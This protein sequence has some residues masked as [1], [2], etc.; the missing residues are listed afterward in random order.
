M[1][2]CDVVLMLIWS[3]RGVRFW[4]LVFQGLVKRVRHGDNYSTLAP[5]RN[6]F[7]YTYM[8]IFADVCVYINIRMHTNMKKKN[9]FPKC[10]NPEA[11]TPKPS[12]FSPC[13]LGVGVR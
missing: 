11:E 9:T 6:P 3:N 1:C 2:V 13:R 5:L 12:S 10:L 8:Y 4:S 7:M